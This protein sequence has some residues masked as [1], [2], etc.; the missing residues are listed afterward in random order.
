MAFSLRT[1][2]AGTAFFAL[3]A[4][5]LFYANELWVSLTFT[6]VFALLILSTLGAVHCQRP[7]RTFW[8]GCAIAAWTY[9]LLVL[10]GLAYI[11]HLRI[12]TEIALDSLHEFVA[13][14]ETLPVGVS[15]GEPK[16]ARVERMRPD[17]S[18]VYIVPYPSRATFR[19]VGNNFFMVIVG[20][21]GGLIAVRFRRSDRE[22]SHRNGPS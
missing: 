3:F 12:V 13:R 8:N 9:F 17:G 2:F 16:L 10:G 6:V 15:P 7:R 18:P 14:D 5:A 21:V 22:E 20:F 4:V 19:D 1:L 11:G